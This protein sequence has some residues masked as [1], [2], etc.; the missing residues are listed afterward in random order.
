MAEV[1][2]SEGFEE[3]LGIV[4]SDKVLDDILRVIEILPTIPSMGST[5][6]A[7][8]LAYEYGE[9][10]RKIPVGPFDIVT[11]YEDEADRVTVL[12]LVHQ[13][14]AWRQHVSQKSSC[15]PGLKASLRHKGGPDETSGP[16]NLPHS[17]D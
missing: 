6:V 17:G 13:R 12:G 1:R 11:F 10:V 4:L 15:N 7:A 3:D 8:A 9:G 2:I 5:D 16:W 14:A